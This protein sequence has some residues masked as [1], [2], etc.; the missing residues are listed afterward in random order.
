[1]GSWAVSITVA[2]IMGGAIAWRVTG[3]IDAIDGRGPDPWKTTAG[4][5]EVSGSLPVRATVARTGIWGL[6]QREVV[7][8]RP[9][10]DSSGRRRDGRCNYLLIESGDPPARWWS[11]AAYRD[12]FL[13]A[14]QG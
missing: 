9:E 6:P 11:V 10:R 5:G 8:F 14:E 1:M 7:Y 3:D 2:L 12:Y 13:G 4:T